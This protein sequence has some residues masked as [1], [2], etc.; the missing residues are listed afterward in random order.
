M[1][2][3][4]RSEVVGFDAIREEEET[5]ELSSVAVKA[6]VAAKKSPAKEKP[7]LE[8]QHV[9]VQDAVPA[10][11]PR[12][13]SKSQMV[14]DTCTQTETSEPPMQLPERSDVEKSVD[15][16]Q[17]VSS[18]QDFV[19]PDSSELLPTEV[20][21]YEGDVA[22]HQLIPPQA[23]VPMVPVVEEQVTQW[24]PL[25]VVCSMLRDQG[26]VIDL[27]NLLWGSTGI[28]E[29]DR[30]MVFMWTLQC[31][32]DLGMLDR[33]VMLSKR[34]EW[35]GLAQ[36]F[37]EF[38][39]L[40]GSLIQNYSYRLVL[41]VQS[42]P[43]L[44]M[45]IS[46]ALTPYASCP[47][48]PVSSNAEEQ[49][50]IQAHYHR[51]LK[52]AIAKENGAEGIAAL[53]ELDKSGKQINVT[54]LSTL[55]EILVKDELLLDATN[56]TENMLQ[57]DTY[58]MPKIFR[59]LLNRLAAT[60]QVEM[61][62][63]IGQY[64]TTGVKKEVSF[65]NRLCNAYLA[66]GRGAEYLEALEQE[67]DSVAG[68]SKDDVAVQVLKD[69]FP[70]GGAM[71]L[72]ESDPNLVDQYTRLAHKFLSFGFVAPVNVLWTYH[73]IN[74]RYD[75]AEKLWHSHVKSCPQIMFQKVCQT[76]RTTGNAELAW[77]LVDLLHNA[78]VTQGARGI[79]YSC[80]ID[81]LTQRGSFAEGCDALRSALESGV[82]LCDINRT[83]L[84]RLKEGLEGNGLQFPY[85]IPKKM[86]TASECGESESS[87]AL[88]CI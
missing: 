61:M 82:L 75:V 63:T 20:P 27:E 30:K 25:H 51:K 58:P 21:T 64:L 70:R 17:P 8:P 7:S 29:E 45:S 65:D 78:T 31:Y 47:S 14:A 18:M 48:T 84:K 79:A 56:V 34:L 28:R 76:A 10:I 38:H 85:D 55:I 50:A 44:S 71:G 6:V 11:E 5:R 15:L 69:K 2:K 49:L 12:D 23:L 22:Q 73:F 80:L 19:V 52:R 77:R 32:V 1:R 54:E 53:N 81:V 60:G 74:G 4:V 72:L 87:M 59:F 9:A 24:Y 33:A 3:S 62:N 39:N 26:R 57:R 41:P 43:A 86:D 35:E 37:P 83:A 36:D 40:M 66:A 13:L 88:A 68:R 42:S 46:P 16:S 67:L